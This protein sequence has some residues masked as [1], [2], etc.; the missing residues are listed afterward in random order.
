VA[1]V[2]DRRAGKVEHEQLDRRVQR[3]RIV[4]ARVQAS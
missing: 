2:D 3:L 4:I 1:V